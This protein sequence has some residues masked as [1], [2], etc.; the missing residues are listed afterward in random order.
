VE[1]LILFD[2]D[3]TL[4]RTQNGYL[5]FNEA[6]LVT[7]GKVGDIRTVVPDGN[8]DPRIVKDIFAQANLKIAI[9]AAD[10][11][12]FTANLRERYQHHVRQGTTAVRPLAGAAELLQMLS[13]DEAFHTTVVTG[14]FEVTAQVKLE[15]AGL[16]QYLA[17]GAYASD[18]E[19][20]PDLPAIAKERWQRLSG[21]IIS[22]RQ[23]IVVGDTPYDLEAARQNNMKCLL[24]GTGRYPVEEL[25]YWQ[26]DACLPD[27]SAT[28]SV[29]HTLTHL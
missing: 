4:T 21:Q 6:I 25:E 5:P 14:N 3:G 2:I 1:R 12:R 22:P 10:W 17:R 20:R 9:D 24:V 8:T 18:S 19:H 27:L 26:P 13:A 16:A 29:V 28:Q 15:A 23:C 11:Q 7:F